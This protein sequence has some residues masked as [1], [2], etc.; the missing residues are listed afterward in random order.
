M[1]LGTFKRRAGGSAFWGVVTDRGIIDMSARTGV[2]SLRSALA[3]DGIAKANAAAGSVPDVALDSVEFLPCILDPV[4]TLCIGLNYDAHRIETN[5]PKVDHPTVF[6]RFP[7]S[8]VGHGAGMVLPKVSHRFDFEG[9]L[10]VVIGK[11]ARHVSRAD[12]LSHVAGYACF[13]DG[14]VRDF[15]R[16]AT[17]F[18]PGKNFVASG[19][20]G[21]WIATADEIPDPAKLTLTTR[22]NGEVVQ[23]SGTHDL[24]FDVPALIEYI[25]Q[26][27]VLEPGDVIATGTPSGV[28]AARKPPLWMK[29]GDSV[30]VEI[31]S[32]GT[33]RNLIVAEA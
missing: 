31:S 25:T 11:T 18:T 27:T 1:K 30:E 26:W 15:Q 32:I 13:N 10:A 24:I 12:A 8:Q 23:Q 20:F 33:L 9:E 5:Q 22:L 19:A 4:R 2:A 17:Q 3:A 28:G 7:S 21:P 29:A 6:V 14:S 16:H